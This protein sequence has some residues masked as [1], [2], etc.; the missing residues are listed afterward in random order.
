MLGLLFIL[1][2]LFI[3]E[4][5]IVRAFDESEMYQSAPLSS[6]SRLDQLSYESLSLSFANP[7]ELNQK[8]LTRLNQLS[9]GKVRLTQMLF[10]KVRPFEL[11]ILNPE[12]YPH[13]VLY[14]PKKNF[15]EFFC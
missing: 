10:L 4:I 3:D 12:V 5:E 2:P 13:L 6:V 1:S 9:Y 11:I 7:L 8:K 15:F 14:F